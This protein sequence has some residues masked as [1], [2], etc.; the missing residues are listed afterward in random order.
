M[1]TDLIV[2]FSPGAQS[3]ERRAQARF[4]GMG[5]HGRGY[6]GRYEGGKI[7]FTRINRRRDTHILRSGIER[8]VRS[9]Y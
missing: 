9:A 4:N 8:N 2:E 1:K 6:G 5:I 3:T 7:R